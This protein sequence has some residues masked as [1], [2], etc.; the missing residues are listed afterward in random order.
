MQ[1]NLFIFWTW[2]SRTRLFCSEKTYITAF[3]KFKHQLRR[4]GIHLHEHGKD[5]AILAFLSLNSAEFIFVMSIETKRLIRV[6]SAAVDTVR[7]TQLLIHPNLLSSDVMINGSREDP[8]STILHHFFKYIESWRT[9]SACSSQL[10]TSRSTRRNKY[11]GQAFLRA[12]ITR[13]P[14]SLR[15]EGEIT[16]IYGSESA[17]PEALE[18]HPL[19]FVSFK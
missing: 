10:R 4:S 12:S 16:I 15:L 3:S 2:N 1:Y 19:F 14:D 17:I 18:S 9:Y 5:Y 13:E 6:G 11:G 7:C 8:L